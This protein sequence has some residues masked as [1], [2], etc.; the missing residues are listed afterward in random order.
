MKGTSKNKDKKSSSKQGKSLKE[1]IQRHLKDKNDVITE[2]DMKE[3]IVG[4]NAVDLQ[5]PDEPSLEEND[6]I[7]AKIETPWNIIRE[8]E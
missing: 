3:V 1:K 2:E 8:K 4:V 7:P 6:I 5:N